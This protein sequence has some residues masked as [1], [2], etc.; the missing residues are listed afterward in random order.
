MGPTTSVNTE[1]V[2]TNGAT[3]IAASMSGEFRQFVSFR[4]GTED[5]AINI[6]AVR[7][8]KGW[9]ATTLLPNQP[10]YVL[11]VLNLRGT[12][13]PIYDLRAR[14][15]LGMTQ[16]TPMHVIMIVS[17]QDRV[18]GL[19]ADAVSDILTV[20][21]AEIREVPDIERGGATEFLAGIIPVGEMMVVLLSLEKL[22]ASPSHA[23][24][25]SHA[26]SMAAAA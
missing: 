15:G 6:M 7:E 11:G 13:V 10:E 19:L 23:A 24:P 9:T 16:T 22:F 8:I 26:A 1:A 3:T 25:P 18:V 4:V 14:F 5:Y 2:A 20:N 12:I 21:S 17:V